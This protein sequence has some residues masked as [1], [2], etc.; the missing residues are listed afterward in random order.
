MNEK[1]R[2]YIDDLFANAPSTVR[3]VE[4]KE[5]LFQNLTDKYNDLLAEGKSE[6]S[7]FNI[8]I[9]SIGDVDSLIS[10]LTGEKRPENEKS[11]KRSAILVAIAISLYILCPVPVILLQSE[12]G[13]MGLFLF[14]AIAT[15]L[16][17]YNGVTRERYVKADDTMVEEFKEWKQNNKQKNKAVDAIIGSFWLIAVCVYI[18]VSFM[19]GAWHITWIIFLIA[20]AVASMIKGLF[21]LKQ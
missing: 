15:A 21:M 2:H 12:I 17:I 20:A 4:L 8:A 3:A 7:A 16:L 9:A 18:V 10:G 1:L 5:E 14:V 11:K 13:V 6:E 19:T